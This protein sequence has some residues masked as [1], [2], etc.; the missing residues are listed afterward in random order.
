MKFKVGQVYKDREG[1]EYRL[2]AFVPEAVEYSQ[3]IFMDL[4]ELDMHW[5]YSDGATHRLSLSNSDILPPE[6]K[7]VKLYPALF[8]NGDDS[9]ACS[10][11]L[12]A[13]CPEYAIRLLTE[14]TAVVVEVD[15]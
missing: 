3:A 12:Y 15:E 4:K 7:T 9:W 8:K 1:N 10:G 14:Y 5:K 2:I 11:A 6:K 13:E